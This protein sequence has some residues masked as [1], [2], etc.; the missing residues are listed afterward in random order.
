MEFY[1]SQ[2]FHENSNIVPEMER[3]EIYSARN[4]FHN[5][6]HHPTSTNNGSFS[7]NGCNGNSGT[8]GARYNQHIATIPRSANSQNDYHRTQPH[9]GI[10]HLIYLFIHKNYIFQF[11]HH[12]F[13][14]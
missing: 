10:S 13:F 7:T 8:N 1:F 6:D 11:I 3:H 9:T 4:N 5:S 2:A 14:V 12:Y